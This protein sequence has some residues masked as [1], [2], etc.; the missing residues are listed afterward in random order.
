MIFIF[1]Y[2][3]IDVAKT[4]IFCWCSHQIPSQSKM[5]SFPTRVPF[6]TYRNYSMWKGF[7]IFVK[8]IGTWMILDRSGSQPWIWIIWKTLKKYLS[9]GPPSTI[10]YLRISDVG[11]WAFIYLNLS[12]W[13]QPPPGNFCPRLSC[14]FDLALLTTSRRHHRQS[15]LLSADGS[16]WLY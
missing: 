12:K 15:T 13:F 16:H 4:K 3:F 11:A 2:L 10:N 8:N 5:N 14:D 9:L 1:F 6:Y 7:K